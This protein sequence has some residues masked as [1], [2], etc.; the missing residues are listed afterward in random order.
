MRS[1]GILDHNI[2]PDL[3]ALRS[4]LASQ[5]LQ[6]SVLGLTYNVYENWLIDYLAIVF[7]IVTDWLG[8]I[9]MLSVN[10]SVLET[11]AGSIMDF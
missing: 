4:S 7:L 8:D 11:I 2:L 6:T 5:N 10:T 9:G 1:F 3:I